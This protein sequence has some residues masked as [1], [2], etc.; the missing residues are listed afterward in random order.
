MWTALYRV[1]RGGKG[2]W[3]REVS[4]AGVS[5]ARVCY[6]WKPTGVWGKQNWKDK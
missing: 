1:R 4:L 3:E 2:S 5:L 6:V